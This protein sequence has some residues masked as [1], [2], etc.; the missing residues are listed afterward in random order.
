V[1]TTEKPNRRLDLG[2]TLSTRNGTLLV[3]AITAVLAAALL[4]IFLSQYRESTQDDGVSASVLVAKRLIER[5]SPGSALAD[6]GMFER[7]SVPRGDLKQGA[8][9][10]PD[11]IKG[12]VAAVDIFP[13]EQLTSSDFAPTVGRVMDRLAPGDRAIA[14]PVD[15]VHGNTA[16]LRAGDR[17]DVLAGFNVGESGGAEGRPVIKPIMRNVLVLTAPVGGGT[18]TADG[19]NVVLRASDRKAADLAFTADHGKLWLLL[20]P[21]VGARDS[22]ISLV[23]MESVLFGVKPVELEQQAQGGQ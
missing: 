5:G 21:Q 2:K 20:R 14:I 22:D 8:I 1:Q 17:V 13:G 18:G 16:N 23:T 3:S 15:A 9:T 4:L 10:D 12:Q 19:Q 11:S 6:Q 7:A